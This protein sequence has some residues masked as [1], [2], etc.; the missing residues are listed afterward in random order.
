MGYLT[1]QIEKPPT[2]NAIYGYNRQGQFLLEDFEVRLLF[3]RQ[4]L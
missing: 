2:S 1:F 3:L 4:Q